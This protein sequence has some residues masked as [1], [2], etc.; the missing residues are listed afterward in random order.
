MPVGALSTQPFKLNR[1]R[2][3]SS[4]KEIVLTKQ[5]PQLPSGNVGA[6]LDGETVS[7]SGSS[8][9]SAQKNL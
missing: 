3:L 5:T 8:G 7:T 1:S 2:S 9:S 4:K 6:V